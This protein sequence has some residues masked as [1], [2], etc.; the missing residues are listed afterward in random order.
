MEDLFAQPTFL[1]FST[2]RKSNSGRIQFNFRYEF[3]EQRNIYAS[4]N[5]EACTSVGRIIFIPRNIK[6]TRYN[7]LKSKEPKKPEAES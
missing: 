5:L 2:E 4:A 3:S 1:V 6:D 7:P